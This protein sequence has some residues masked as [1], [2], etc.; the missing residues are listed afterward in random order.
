MERFRQANNL[1]QLMLWIEELSCIGN[2][3]LFKSW[4]V[5]SVNQVGDVKNFFYV[6]L[7]WTKI[8]LHVVDV[9]Q[10]CLEREQ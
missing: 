4:Q 2:D 5:V 1:H 3:L 6:Q 9:L 8:L 10:H 7:P